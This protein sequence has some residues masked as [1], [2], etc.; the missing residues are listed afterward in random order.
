MSTTRKIEGEQTPLPTTRAEE[1]AGDGPYKVE[2]DGSDKNE[3]WRWT[4]PD[5]FGDWTSELR[6]SHECAELNAAYKQGQQDRW[7][8]VESKLP[9]ELPDGT[10]VLG[11][12]SVRMEPVLAT[13]RGGLPFDV[14]NEGWDHKN[15]ITHWA[16]LPPNPEQR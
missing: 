14:W 7:I 10:N 8:S 16:P 9:E 6:A 3:R 5:S 15:E 13:L 12:N 4:G 1:I 2:S 11:W